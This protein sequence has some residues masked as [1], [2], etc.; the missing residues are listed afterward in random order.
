MIRLA[1]TGPEYL[2]LRRAGKSLNGEWCQIAGKIE[3]D[4]HPVETVRREVLEET[5]I[6]VRDIYSADRCEQFYEVHKN[7]IVIAPVFVVFVTPDQHV[8]INH[9]HSEFKW[10]KFEQAL[11]SLPFPGQRENLTSIHLNFGLVR[12]ASQLK[13]APQS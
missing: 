3:R 6:Y 5:G 8:T 11:A 12:P 9:E 13:I 4:E 7:R 1:P 2:L 10:M